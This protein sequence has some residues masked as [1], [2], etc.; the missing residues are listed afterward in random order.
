MKTCTADQQNYVV[1]TTNSRGGSFNPQYHFVDCMWV[2]NKNDLLA[3]ICEVN[4]TQVAGSRTAKGPKDADK[5]ASSDP[6]F[7]ELVDTILTDFE[8]GAF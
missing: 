8:K 2:G 5:L 1:T 6:K 7:Q 4:A 3:I